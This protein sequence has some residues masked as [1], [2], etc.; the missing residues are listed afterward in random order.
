MQDYVYGGLSKIVQSFK[1]KRDRLLTAT[2][3][4]HV[5]TRNKTEKPRGSQG[6]G[7]STQIT[8]D[9]GNGPYG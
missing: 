1:R 6:T 7:K 2:I 3:P 5:R 9:G 8:K 4:T